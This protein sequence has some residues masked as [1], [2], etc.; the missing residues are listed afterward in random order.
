MWTMSRNNWPGLLDRSAKESGS[1]ELSGAK[2]RRNCW[3]SAA[4]RSNVHPSPVAIAVRGS[5]VTV[6]VKSDVAVLPARSVAVHV[7]V[8]TPTVKIEPDAGSHATESIPTLSAD[9]GSGYETG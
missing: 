1:P 4:S 9:V 6:T 5:R 2:M 3:P 8:V 7:T